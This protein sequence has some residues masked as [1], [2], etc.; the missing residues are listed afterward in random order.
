M[1]CPVCKKGTLK[2]VD[3][4]E[5]DKAIKCNK[6]GEYGYFVG[7]ILCIKTAFFGESGKGLTAKIVQKVLGD[8]KV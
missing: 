1:K 5:S 6:C 3:G 8:V 7:N 2:V 4:W